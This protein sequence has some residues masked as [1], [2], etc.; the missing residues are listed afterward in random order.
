VL[1]IN[2][3]RED[4]ELCL[5]LLDE[6]VAVLPGSVFGFPPT[7]HVVVSLRTEPDALLGGL[8]ALERH[9]RGIA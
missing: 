6:G 3:I 4:R 7:G 8:E 9:L 1:Q 2:P 5:E